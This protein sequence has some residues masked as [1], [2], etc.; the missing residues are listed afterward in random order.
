TAIENSMLGAAHSAGNPLTAHFNLV[1]G[2][3]VGLMLPH[4]V[5]YNAADPAALRAYA[6][7]ASTPEIASVD[8]GLEPAC[9]A[10]VI[11]LE[12]LLNRAGFPRSLAECGVPRSM[13]PTLAREAAQQWTAGFNPRKT[14]VDDF[15][16]LYEAAFE[17]RREGVNRP[18]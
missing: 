1:H 8:D 6:D 10:V 15:V 11:R 12:Q 16:G 4:V 5:R 18:I 3:A 9:G 17:P 14:E 2:Q 13:I 7:L